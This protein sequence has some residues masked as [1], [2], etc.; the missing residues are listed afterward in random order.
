MH[1]SR[2]VIAALIAGAVPPALINRV[3]QEVAKVL[4]AEDVQQKLFS[5]EGEVVVSTPHS[6][7]LGQQFIVDNR[8]AMSADQVMQ[9]NS[10]MP[11]A[12]PAGNSSAAWTEKR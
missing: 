2:P 7:A 8:G 5:A 11:L 9:R 4:K 6:D 3:Q 12:R 10:A 1:R